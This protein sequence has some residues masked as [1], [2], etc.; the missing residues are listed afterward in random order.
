MAQFAVIYLKILAEN[1]YDLE[2]IENMPILK[3]ASSKYI[4]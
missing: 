2:M 1:G 4:C 3:L